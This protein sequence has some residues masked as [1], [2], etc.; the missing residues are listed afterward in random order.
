M[1][2]NLERR[3]TRLE[4]TRALSN[5]RVFIVK[6]RT[7]AEHEAEIEALKASGEASEGDL[8]IR[9]RFVSSGDVARRLRP[10]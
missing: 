4:E 5:E 10:S 2:T 8:F 9:I 3:L 7:S 1:N 6:G